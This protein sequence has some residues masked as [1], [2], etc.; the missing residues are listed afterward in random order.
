MPRREDTESNRRKRARKRARLKPWREVSKRVVRGDSPRADRSLADELQPIKEVPRSATTHA[1]STFPTAPMRRLNTALMLAIQRQPGLLLVTGEPG[2]GKSVFAAYFASE[3]RAAG[4]PVLVNGPASVALN[5]QVDLLRAWHTSSNRI[6]GHVPP[7]L[8]SDGGDLSLLQALRDVLPLLD[9]DATDSLGIRAVLIGEPS[10]RK[11]FDAPA[12]ERLRRRIRFEDRLDP[13]GKEDI[14][15]FI[16]S[17]AAGPVIIT[18][19]VL[20]AIAQESH[21]LPA[22]VQ[23]LWT[24]AQRFAEDD[25]ERIP[26]AVHVEEAAGKLQPPSSI[27][28]RVSDWLGFRGRPERS[29][30][31]SVPGW[32]STRLNVRKGAVGAAMMALIAVFW[33]VFLNESTDRNLTGVESQPVALQP[34]PNGESLSQQQPSTTNATPQVAT[35]PAAPPAQQQP[36]PTPPVATGPGTPEPAQQQSATPQIANGQV[37]APTRQQPETPQVGNGPSTPGQQQLATAKIENNRA[38]TPPAPV[39]RPAR[40]RQLARD[41]TIPKT[42]NAKEPVTP[43]LPETAARRVPPNAAEPRLVPETAP[44]Q[45]AKTSPPPG[46]PPVAQQSPPAKR[47]PGMQLAGAGSKPAAA[48]HCEPYVSEVDFALHK[49]R[50]R[51]LACQDASGAWWLVTQERE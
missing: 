5:A 1:A 45:L 2:V 35:G 31:R 20:G 36:N 46:S 21:G 22:K 49:E 37:T 28:A 10:L 26:R 39:P 43:R 8:L 40:T 25:E 18:T 47:E 13:L 51:G 29:E 15:Q 7:V 38:M 12:F 24:Q 14:L 3:L 42:A 19:D 30:R 41:A 34:A 9:V 32:L 50:V 4:Y 23:F 44:N 27:G 17:T 16:Q 48:Q 11:L 33:T 6:F